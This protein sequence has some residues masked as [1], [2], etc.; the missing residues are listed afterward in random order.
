MRPRFPVTS[1]IPMA[2][3]SI[4]TTRL[5]AKPCPASKFPKPLTRADR[6]RGCGVLDIDWAIA[7]MAPGFPCAVP[8]QKPRPG[9]ACSTAI[10]ATNMPSVARIRRPIV[11][12]RQRSSGSASS[13]PAAEYNST[14]PGAPNRKL[15][16]GAKIPPKAS[17]NTQTSKPQMALAAPATG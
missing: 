4:T 16:P 9:H 7:A 17:P 11:A 2:A 10:A 14:A 8:C 12:V 15:R 6:K 5:T 1:A 3:S 13:R